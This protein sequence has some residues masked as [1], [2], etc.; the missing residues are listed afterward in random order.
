MHLS[1]EV[2]Q[3]I[4]ELPTMEGGHG[5]N[6]KLESNKGIVRVW[7]SRMMVADGAAEDNEVTVQYFDTVK[8]TWEVCPPGV[9]STLR[10]IK[11]ALWQNGHNDIAALLEDGDG[12][13]AG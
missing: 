4:A 3:K 7:S 1:A 13:G 6:L 11:L 12:V 9:A 8:N 5:D 10:L 2:R